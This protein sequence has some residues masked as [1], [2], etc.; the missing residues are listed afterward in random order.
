MAVRR[1]L[2]VWDI[3]NVQPPDRW[4]GRVHCAY[5]IG[6]LLVQQGAGAA[7]A[8]LDTPP[9][10]R[11][12]LD[13]VLVAAEW[14]KRF[15]ENWNGDSC[16]E[17]WRQRFADWH[18][19]LSHTHNLLLLDCPGKRSK[20]EAEDKLGEAITCFARSCHLAANPGIVLLLS[21]VST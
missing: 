2:I 3:E 13:Q 19:A 18:N 17:K 4:D 21:T 8:L 11:C 10:E 12:V 9:A 6:R 14:A 15:K 16:D 7:G 5:H 20:I 1:V